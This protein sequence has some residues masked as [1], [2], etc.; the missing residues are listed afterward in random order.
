ML[1]S[2]WR[3]NCFVLDGAWCV[4]CFVGDGVW[5][6][7][8]FAVR[9]AWRGSSTLIRTVWR[10]I[11]SVATVAYGH[12]LVPLHVVVYTA[13]SVA[14]RGCVSSA[15][16]LDRLVV[17]PVWRGINFACSGVWRLTCWLG[18]G[19]Y[20]FVLVPLATGFQSILDAATAGLLILSNAGKR[21]VV[22]VHLSVLQPTAQAVS[23]MLH[24]S[25]AV[26]ASIVRQGAEVAVSVGKPVANAVRNG[27]RAVGEAIID[28]AKNVKA[29]VRE[30]ALALR[31]FV[32][33]FVRTATGRGR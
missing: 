12:L 30:G 23:Q 29:K 1:R 2:I 27:A 25:A 22:A 24:A 16:A 5:R 33:A 14:W 17:T 26:I 31:A 21:A 19:V 3:V 8:S 20:A 15:H 9:M 13:L 11:S 18:P 32:M 4:A 6:A 10:T 28:G 7:T